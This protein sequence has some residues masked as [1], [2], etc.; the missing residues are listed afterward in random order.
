M[1]NVEEMKT[2]VVS[3]KEKM[4][5]GEVTMAR[6]ELA[7]V[8]VIS[9]LTGMVLGLCKGLKVCVGKKDKECK[10]SKDDCCQFE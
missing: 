6:K 1:M 5:G 8:V 3:A 2:Q 4:F 9:V 7:L 10:C